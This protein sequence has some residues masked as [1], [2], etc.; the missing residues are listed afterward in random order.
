MTPRIAWQPSAPPPER[1][2][3][4]VAP[5]PD[6]SCASPEHPVRV[7][8]A[9]AAAPMAREEAHVTASAVG[10]VGG[11]EVADCRIL[12]GHVIDCLRSLPD[13]SVHC[14]VTS[15]PYWGLRKYAGATPLVWGG[16]P[17]CEHEW[18]TVFKPAANGIVHDGGMSG[19][20]LSGNSATRGPQKSDTCDRCGAW[21]GDLGLEPTWQQFIVNIVAVFREVRRVLRDDGVVALNLGDCFATAPAGNTGPCNDQDGAFMRRNARQRAATGEDPQALLAGKGKNVP[22]SKNPGCDYPD[23]APHR[24][25][26]QGIP[27]KCKMLLPHRVAIALIDDG[28]I[29]RQDC[30]WHKRNPL[31]ESVRDRPTTNHEYVFLLSKQ[32]KYWWDAEAVRSPGAAA[33]ADRYKYAFSGAPDGLEQPGGNERLRPE[34]NRDFDGTANMRSVI[35]LCAEPFSAKS[36]GIEGVDH[37]A[38]Y[39]SGLVRPFILAGC[40]ERC[41]PRCGAGWVREATRELVGADD[42]RNTK[43]VPGRKGNGNSRSSRCG[44]GVTKTFGYRPGCTCPH[45]ITDTV[46]GTVLDPFLGSGTTAEEALEQFRRAIGCELSADYVKIAQARIQRGV[47]LFTRGGVTVTALDAGPTP[48]PPHRDPRAR[49]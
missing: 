26:W 8:P 32:P 28:W 20:T 34:G 14:V 6:T 31:P 25:Q 38:S 7:W 48:A 22:Q 1:P 21:R 18:Q 35:S 10:A 13:K 4:A 2:T 16:A 15:P 23:A 24:S 27:E 40:P 9:P 17:G 46:P 45:E 37:F 19:E 49:T 36:V 43:G 12:H 47:G 3:P 11:A 30:V 33:S 41:C 39:P 29:V 42:V 5:M 44:F